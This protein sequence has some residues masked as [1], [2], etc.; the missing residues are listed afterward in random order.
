MAA[1]PPAAAAPL[2]K[3]LRLTVKRVLSLIIGSSN[4]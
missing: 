4:L 3:I 2:R 1:A